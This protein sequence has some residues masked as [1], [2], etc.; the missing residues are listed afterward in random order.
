[1][2]LHRCRLL[3]G[4]S[5]SQSW[6]QQSEIK[7]QNQKKLGRRQSKSRVLREAAETRGVGSSS[8]QAPADGGGGML[9]PSARGPSVPT[10]IPPIS[11]ES[12]GAAQRRPLE[13]RGDDT[14]PA[15]DPQVHLPGSSA[16]EN[17]RQGP[18]RD[19]A[20]TTHRHQFVGPQRMQILSA[21][22]K[23]GSSFLCTLCFF[24]YLL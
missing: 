5:D 12:K 7:K 23:V 24:I 16:P 17:Q 14:H 2:R 3:S 15:S 18:S 20:Q 8:V 11:A 9:S 4:F 22:W 6:A 13:A 1:M 21:A 19:P 10:R